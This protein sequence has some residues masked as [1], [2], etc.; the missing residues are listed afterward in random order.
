MEESCFKERQAAPMYEWN[1]TTQRIIDWIEAHICEEFTLLQISEYTGYSPFY[2]SVQF[3]KVTGRTI[4]TY[5]ADRRLSL[6]ALALRDTE[7]RIIDIAVRY[8]YSSQEALTRAFSAAF[9]CTPA[10]YRKKPLPIPLPIRQVV[11]LPEHYQAMKGAQNMSSTI[12]TEANV[13]V[14]FIPAHKY[15]GIWDESAGNYG[16]FWQRHDCDAVC[17]IVDSMSHSS[18]L[19]ITGHTAGWKRINGE[20][21]YFYGTGLP[22]DYSGPVPE[23]FEVRDIPGSYYLL[24]FHPAFDYLKDNGEVM[25]RVE[26]LAWNYDIEKE[27]QGGR[28]TWNEE[29]C[30][31][32]QRHY[33]EVLGYQVLRPIRRKL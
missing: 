16:E 28:Y 26:Q 14:E 20:L 5:V 11:Y 6:I 8:G 24:F 29:A 19:I 25:N 31:C 13:R 30:P 18:D 27:F 33:P 22:V 2:C 3:H 21:R 1:K 9:G 15:M 12:L 10:S 23:G 32:Y 4:K 7:E 17:G